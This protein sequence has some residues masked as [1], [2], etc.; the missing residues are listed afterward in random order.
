MI[1]PKIQLTPHPRGLIALKWICHNNW[2]IQ[3]YG[4]TPKEAYENW[5]SKTTRYTRIPRRGYWN[6]Q[7]CRR[8]YMRNCPRVRSYIG[9]KLIVA[10]DPTTDEL[11]LQG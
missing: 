9:T 4:N 7:D 5:C 1:K 2:F 10:Y 11:L 8:W 3:G 6:M